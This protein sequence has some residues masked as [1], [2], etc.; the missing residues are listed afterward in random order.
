M[1]FRLFDDIL[2]PEPIT[3]QL[4]PYTKLRWVPQAKCPMRVDVL[5]NKCKGVIQIFNLKRIIF[6][7][8]ISIIVF[9]HSGVIV[10]LS[11]HGIKLNAFTPSSV[12]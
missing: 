8:S 11:N 6:T 12:V 1:V 10:V 2:L 4:F 5:K 7:F 9:C 3:S